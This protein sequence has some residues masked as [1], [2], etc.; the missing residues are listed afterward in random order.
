MAVLIMSFFS[1]SGF[2]FFFFWSLPDLFISGNVTS[3]SCFEITA[4]TE[5]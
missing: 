1:S 2:F 5:L 3:N 4:L